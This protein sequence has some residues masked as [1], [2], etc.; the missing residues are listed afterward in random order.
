MRPWGRRM[1]ARGGARV[2][3]L[4]R[5]RPAHWVVLRVIPRAIAMRFDPD[6]ADG[7]QATLQLT[8][9]DPRGGAPAHFAL[10]IAESSCSVRSGAAEH[11]GACAVVASDDLILLASG[12]ASWPELLSSGRF[13]LSGDPFLAL[14]FAALFK[15]PVAL[16]QV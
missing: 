16:E 12:A 3:R 14:R 13:E 5:R 4:D 9:R 11:P 7:L 8:I 1:L 6:A 15:L 2:A 10:A